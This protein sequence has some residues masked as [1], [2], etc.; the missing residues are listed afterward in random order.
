MAVRHRLGDPLVRRPPTVEP[1][2]VGFDPRFVEEDEAA[3][4]DGEPPGVERFP[5]LGDVRPALFGGL[6]SFF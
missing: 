5:S 2:H 4:I 1:G 3:G 6:E